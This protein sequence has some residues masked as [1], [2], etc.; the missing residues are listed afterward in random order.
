V[1]YHFFIY[2]YISFCIFIAY[3]VKDATTLALWALDVVSKGLCGLDG[4]LA[5]RLG[6]SVLPVVYY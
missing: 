3:E 4:D 1:G 2:E 6:L 5:K